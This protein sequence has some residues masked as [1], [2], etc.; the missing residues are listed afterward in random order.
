MFCGRLG[1]AVIRT[2]NQKERR[3][4]IRTVNGRGGVSSTVELLNCGPEPLAALTLSIW[5]IAQ[6][7]LMSLGQASKARPDL[8]Q[9][10][11]T[12][13]HKYGLTETCRNEITMH[14]LTLPLLNTQQSNPT[15]TMLLQHGEFHLQ[16]HG[17]SRR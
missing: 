15:A 13:C 1:G 6:S 10:L 7:D 3:R 8:V 11:E 9:R 12:S 4:A 17:S 16:R 2:G 14:S 5:A